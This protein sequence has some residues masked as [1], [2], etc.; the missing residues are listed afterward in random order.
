M[1]ELG[2]RVLVALVG[3]PVAIAALWW[4]DAPLAALLSVFGALGAWEYC[5]LSAGT[6]VRP[7]GR[8]SVLLAALVPLL[9]HGEAVGAVRVPPSVWP[10][11]PLALLALAIWRRPPGERPLE[12]SAASVMAVVYT[13]VPLSSLYLLRTHP[14]AVGRT[15]GFLVALLPLVLTWAS[16][17]GGYVA[18]RTIGGR[19]L[20]PRV[21]PG[22][23]VAGAVGGV[24]LTVVVAVALERWMLVPHAQLGF[25]PTGRVL[26]GV[27][28]SVVA[29]VGDLAESLLKREAGVKDSGSI[30]PGHG[31]VLD[32]LDSLF[33]VA[34]T[35]VVLYDLLLI[36]AIRG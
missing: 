10:L 9:V 12:A 32:R 22:K 6:G 3:A 30:F 31:G 8:V 28:V 11:V 33:F 18:G 17:I 29:Q 34:P 23:T 7:F 25:T 26:F 35:A 2:K 14:Y 1:G 20:I 27:A 24:L 19:K 13:A 4:G 36:P 5:R 15:A 16:D 21:S